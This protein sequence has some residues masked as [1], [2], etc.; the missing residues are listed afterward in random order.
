MKNNLSQSFGNWE[1]AIAQS[2]LRNIER[3][4]PANPQHVFAA[5][6]L[7]EQRMV[8]LVSL[9]KGDF[10]SGNEALIES[11]AIECE[12]GSLWLTLGTELRDDILLLPG[13][14]YISKPDDN[15]LIEALED[16]RF[17]VIESRRG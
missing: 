2:V 10:W 1:N 4:L 9:D 11:F 12:S 7:D 15:I 8:G 3:H 16:S 14:T 5:A 6:R 17:R 13:Q